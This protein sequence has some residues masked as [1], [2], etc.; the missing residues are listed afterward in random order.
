MRL[1]S[2]NFCAVVESAQERLQ[3][4]SLTDVWCEFRDGVLHLRGHTH[5]FYHKQ[6]AQEAVRSLNCVKTVVNEIEVDYQT[7]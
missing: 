3:R 6:L 7:R 4:R 1:H 2:P 5:R